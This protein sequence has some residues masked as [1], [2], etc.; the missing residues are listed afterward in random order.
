MAGMDLTFRQQREDRPRHKKK[1]IGED[2]MGV[3]IG[4]AA[5]ILAAG[6][7]A[8]RYEDKKWVSGLYLFGIWCIWTLLGGLRTGIGTDYNH[9]YNLFYEAGAIQTVHDLF[10]QREEWLYLLLNKLVYL[11]SAD[12]RVYLLLYSGLLYMGFLIFYQRY[13]RNLSMSLWLFTAFEFFAISLCFMRQAAAILLVL[14]AYVGLTKGKRLRAVIL[15]LLGA[16]F[17][18]SALC[19]LAAVVLGEIRWSR[20]RVIA[21]CASTGILLFAMRWILP[22]LLHTVLSRYQVYE[23]TPFLENGHPALAFFPAVLGAWILY[24]ISR[25]EKKWEEREHRYAAIA[26]V[27]GIVMALYSCQYLILERITLYF[28]AYATVSIPQIRRDMKK[29]E[30]E[31]GFYY[32]TAVGMLLFISLVAFVFYLK[33]D[34]YGVVPYR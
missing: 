20:G 4:N 16:G 26:A 14:Y 5:A 22:V 27:L 1:S 21:A 6:W 18:W 3:Y 13:S 7:I 2:R 29:K 25:T 24:G 32:K 31:D 9:Y 28:S 8:H 10:S 12:F 34:R 33:N 17:H 11:F 30:Q 15:I 23:G 19:A